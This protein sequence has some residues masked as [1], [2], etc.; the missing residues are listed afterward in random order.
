[1]GQDPDKFLLAG[2][3]RKK[4]KQSTY[5]ISID[6][7]ELKRKSESYI[8]KCKSNFV[9]TEFTMWD[10]G[11]NP[12]KKEAGDVRVELGV[13]QYDRNVLGTNGPR[14]MQVMLPPTAATGV[15]DKLQPTKVEDTMSCVLSKGS[16]NNY[17]KLVNKTPRWNESL[18][19]FCL[20]FQGRVTVLQSRTFSWWTSVTKTE[21]CCSLASAPTICS[22]WT[23]LT[24]CA[25]CRLSRSACP[26]LTTSWL[27]SEASLL[28]SRMHFG[29]PASGLQCTLGGTRDVSRRTFTESPAQASERRGS[30]IGSAHVL[31]NS[32]QHWFDHQHCTFSMIILIV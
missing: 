21:S 23:T 15:R 28:K 13:V 25:R 4:N 32:R 9:G 12:G 30:E 17:V 18:G 8:G 1:M 3:R 7:K 2:R 27:A 26:R 31:P 11:S 22:L 20:N 24:R 16:E 29:L 19:A 10:S 14:K 5:L 6:E